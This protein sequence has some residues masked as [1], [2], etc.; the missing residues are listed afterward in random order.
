MEQIF[1]GSSRAQVRPSSTTGKSRPEA[2][3]R[4]TLSCF[5]KAAVPDDC[6]GRSGDVIIGTLSGGEM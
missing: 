5:H 2:G 4:R 6:A 1:Y 3:S